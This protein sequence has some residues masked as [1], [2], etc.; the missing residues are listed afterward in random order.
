MQRHVFVN[1]DENNR[2]CENVVALYSPLEVESGTAALIELANCSSNLRISYLLLLNL[3]QS[4]TR[5]K[6]CT[7]GAAIQ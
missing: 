5:D 2:A 3:H 4:G 6:T 7:S 1:E